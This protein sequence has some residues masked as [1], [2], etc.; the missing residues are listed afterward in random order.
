LL[1]S[2]KF[3]ADLDKKFSSSGTGAMS[4]QN[5]EQKETKYT[6]YVAPNMD[7]TAMLVS[8]ETHGRWRTDLA[9]EKHGPSIFAKVRRKVLFRKQSN[10][11]KTPL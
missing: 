6:R 4:C 11:T 1:L 5:S 3:I 10:K 8:A 9:Q 7:G 2:Q